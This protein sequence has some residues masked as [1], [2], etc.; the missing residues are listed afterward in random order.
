MTGMTGDVFYPG[1]LRGIL[2]LPRA[3]AGS[4]VLEEKPF[5]GNCLSGSGEKEHYLDQS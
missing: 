4:Q 5:L 2:P 1:T 3:V